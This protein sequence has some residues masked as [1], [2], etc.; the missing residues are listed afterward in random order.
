MRTPTN[1]YTPLAWYWKGPIGIF[2]SA[3][4]RLVPETDANYQAF[5]SA[6]GG[7]SPWPTDSN[8]EQT[9]A[10]LDGVLAQYGLSTGLAIAT[11]SQL[12]DYAGSKVLSLLSAMRLYTVDGATIKSDSTVGTITHLLAL[13]TWGQSNPTATD[14]WIANDWSST[15]VTGAQFVA[16]APLVGA[17]AQ[18]IY[19][20]ELNMVLAQI[21]AGTITTTAQIDSFAWTL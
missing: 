7:V 14:N 17:Y 6:R 13:S 12:Q 9:I 4:M 3:D 16:L 1:I 11:L 8:G 20:T 19:G 10:A 21:T 5:L 15:P 18:L 2:S